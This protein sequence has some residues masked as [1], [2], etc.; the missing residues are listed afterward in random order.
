M[1]GFI[2]RAVAVEP[3]R[4]RQRR[5]AGAAPGDQLRL[6]LR[7]KTVEARLRIGRRQLQHFQAVDAVRHVAEQRGIGGADD[8][9]ARVVDLAAGVEQLVQL[10]RGRAF[11]VDDGQAL[12]PAGDV[13]IGAR[14]VQLAGVGQRHPRRQQHRLGRQRHVDHAQAALVGDEQ[15]AELQRRG[16]RVAQR[17]GGQVARLERVVQVDDDHAGLGRD[18]GDM[19]AEHDVARAVEQPVRV[20]G[21]RALEEIVARLAIGQRIDID[22]DQALFGVA[23]GRVVIDRVERLLLVGHAHQLALVARRRD[24][25]AGR[26][27]HAGGVLRR[28]LGVLAERRIGRGDDPLRDALVGDVGHVIDPQPA[29]AFGG[30]QVF[31]AQLQA[32]GRALG[33]VRLRL[34]QFHLAA[35]MRLVPVGIGV[36]LQITALDRLRLVPLGDGGR[37]DMAGLADPRVVADEI[38]E[39]GSLQQQ[40][41]HDGVVVVRF[42]DVAIAAR[43]GL[44]LALGVRVMRRERL[45]GKAAGRDR[46]LLNINFFAVGVDRRQHQR[47]TGAHR[48]NLATL[49]RT[50][51]AQ[52]EHVVARHLR[53]VGRIVARLAALVVQLFGFPVGLDRQVAAGAT[54]GPRQVAA[55]AAHLVVVV[56]QC[57]HAR[58]PLAVLAV[59]AGAHQLGARR[60]LVVVRVTGVDRIFYQA[61]FPFLVRVGRGALKQ[62]AL[63]PFEALAP[64][65]GFQLRHVHAA[66]LGGRTA[67]AQG[68]VFTG[69]AMAVGAIDFDRGRH[70]AVNVAVAMAVLG[71]VAIDALHALFHVDRGQVHGFLELVRIVVVNDGA[72]GVEQRAL[73]VALEDGPKIPAVPVV[74]GKLGVFQAGIELADVFQE[75]GIAPVAARGR[76]FRVARLDRADLGVGRILLLLRPHRRRVRL[77]IP[78]RVAVEGIDENVRLVHVARHALRGRDGAREFVL[79]RMAR[80]VARDGRVGAGAG[81]HVAGRRV[82]PGMQRIAVICIHH[83]AGGAAGRTVVAG[84]LVGAQ[85]PQVRV[86]QA[87]LGDVNRR[88]RNAPAGARTPVRLVD[89]GP[90]RL[91]ELLQGAR[92]VGQAHFRELARDD[93]PAALEDAKHVPWRDGFPGRQRI[94]A[95]Q[96]AFLHEQRIVDPDRIEDRRRHPVRRVRLAQDVTFIG[97]HAIVV[98]GAAPQHGRGRHEAALLGL[99]DRQVAGAAGVARHA[100]VAW[101]EEAHIG[102]VFLVQL[103]VRGLRIGRGRIVPEF[104]V[105]WR[106]VGAIERGAVGRAGALGV[107]GRARRFRPRHLRIAAVAIGAAEHHGRIGVHG[108]AVRGG[109]ATEAAGRLAVGLGLTLGPRRRR[110]ADIR[111]LGQRR[112]RVGARQRRCRFERGEQHGARGQQHQ[113]QGQQGAQ[114]RGEKTFGQHHRNNSISR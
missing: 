72:L 17:D 36:A 108:V 100:Q 42:R 31:A 55:V 66:R 33:G 4:Q 39:I 59:G 61:H 9:V 101:I 104:F 1:P 20:P 45:R 11:D 87:R 65:L 49:D 84:L 29:L 40:L 105:R 13:G 44:F 19:A 15:V 106:H 37:L 97:Q 76:F 26:Q 78:H 51:N 64:V 30:K 12:A 70:F 35:Q 62:L 24:R 48:R 68:R 10:R 111:V 3:F 21:Q 25:L 112:R 2:D 28:H 74:V 102:R 94:Q 43:L 23:D 6:R 57:R 77:V 75:I 71:K 110:R 14:Q 5:R 38:D 107:G 63:A 92:T 60:F 22:Q 99:D 109:V 90:A 69:A 32:V 50:G 114:R 86:V 93:P 58:P 82:R 81:A 8:D 95:V 85:K 83:V 113:R 18:V 41:G 79:D 46:R 34:G 67:G 27:R 80:L 91:V 54:G 16:A 98:A 52:L 7:R 56:R 47:R 103:G 89:I 53:I 88:H 73:A 96:N